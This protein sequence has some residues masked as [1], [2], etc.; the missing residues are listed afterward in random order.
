M[1][2]GG[3]RETRQSSRRVGFSFRAVS[4][5]TPYSERQ[6]EGKEG[7]KGKRARFV[8][9]DGP[10]PVPAGFADFKDWRTLVHRQ[11]ASASVRVRRATRN[12]YS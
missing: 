4:S 9:M 8:A 5:R 12:F 7:R 3:F 2:R 1:F 6:R 10:Y 11:A